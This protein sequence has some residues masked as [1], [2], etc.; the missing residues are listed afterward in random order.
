MCC[1]FGLFNP[2]SKGEGSAQTS[3]RAEGH[4]PREEGLPLFHV[5]V[6]YS[7]H[8][9]AVSLHSLISIHRCGCNNNDK[10]MAKESVY[11]VIGLKDFSIGVYTTIKGVARAIGVHR[12]TIVCCDRRVYGDYM[13]VGTIVHKARMGRAS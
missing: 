5:D 1:V 4:A 12:N 7:A 11:V 8:Q 6:C 13:V 3:L 10:E 9:E 2:K